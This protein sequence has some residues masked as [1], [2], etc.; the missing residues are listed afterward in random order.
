[1]P[2]LIGWGE[3]QAREALRSMGVADARI[4]ADY[5]DRSV[6]GPVFDDFAPYTVVSTTPDVGEVIADGSTITLGIRA[7]APPTATPATA[8]PDLIGWGEN[9]ARE[10]LRRIGVADARIVADYQDRN[11]LGPV[12]DDFAPYTVVST[13]PNVGGV[14]AD[15]T[16]IILGVRAPAAVPEPEL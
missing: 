15:D 12:F 11:V 1:M 6:L 3:N 4:V 13:T 2:D 8:M 16:T 5:Q 9:Q 7:P 10:A 14:I